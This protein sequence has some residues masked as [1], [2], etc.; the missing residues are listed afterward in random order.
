[1]KPFFFIA[2]GW[3]AAPALAWAQSSGGLP[4]EGEGMGPSPVQDHAISE[5]MPAA[6][7]SMLT[8]PPGSDGNTST[9]ISGGNGTVPAPGSLNAVSAGIL[10]PP[11]PPGSSIS[12]P[13][14]SPDNLGGGNSSLLK[15]L[16]P[17]VSS[18]GT[19]ATTGGAAESLPQ[20]TMPNSMEMLD[21]QH[22]LATGD[23]IYYEVVEDREPQPR[24]LMVD[25][26]GQID[27]PYL[28]L[29]PV[30]GETLS[31]MA[32]AV[33]KELESTLYYHATVLAVPYTID[34]TRQPVLVMG[35]VN[36]P[37]PITVPADDVLTL[38]KAILDAG[39]LANTADA[40]RV[41]VLRNDRSDPKASTKREF[42]V[43]EIYTKGAPDPLVEPG[44]LVLVPQKDEPNGSVTIWGAVRS[45]GVMPLPVGSNITVSQVVIQAGGFTEW[46]DDEVKLVHYDAEGKRHEQWVEVGQVLNKG[47]KEKDVKVEPGDLIIVS[48][49]WINF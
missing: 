48:Q 17:A 35:A 33:Q 47:Q 2:V 37:G 8:A 26:K 22:K 3:L 43:E 5:L 9:P 25:E 30:A 10:A 4:P 12:I 38:F 24:V 49:K 16:P 21:K 13:G 28:G 11:S 32:Y 27:V 41:E 39:G 42:N 40:K 19:G 15:V 23:R 6:P 31:E 36:R 44:D 1:M 34:R 29:R 20:V 14:L 45:P 46:G 18:A 7:P